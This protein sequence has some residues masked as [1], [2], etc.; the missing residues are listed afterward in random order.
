MNELGTIQSES[1]KQQRLKD[2]MRH[3]TRQII[4]EQEDD[5]TDRSHSYDSD[6]SVLK[7]D[8]KQRENEM[9]FR[10]RAIQDE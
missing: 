7:G 5:L 6:D 4:K 10:E 3:R 1:L 9:A 8:I 2:R